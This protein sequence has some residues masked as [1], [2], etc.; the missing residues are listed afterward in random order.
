MSPSRLAIS[1]GCLSAIAACADFGPVGPLRV[2][3]TVDVPEVSP[4][5]PARMSV[6]STNTTSSRIVWGHGSSSCQLDAA[7]QLNG[8]WVL[9]VPLRACTNDAVEHGLEP[10]E[11][12]TELLY[13]DG[14]VLRGEQSEQ[15]PPG[16][17]RVRG[18]A[19][20]MGASAATLITIQGAA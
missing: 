13:W 17:Y 15:L 8:T 20:D 10:G 1:F 7:A 5:A 18:Q 4:S 11:V 3:I 6:T 19:G 2:T 14:R 12:R 16:R 9:I